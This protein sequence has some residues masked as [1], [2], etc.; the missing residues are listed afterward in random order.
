MPDREDPDL[1]PRGHEP[2]ER[3][4]SCAPERDHELTKIVIDDAANQWVMDEHRDRRSDRF[5][6]V[7]SGLGCSAGQGQERAL[8]IRDRVG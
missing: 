7:S 1:V 4:I 3:H 2:V 5:R 6:C 8:E